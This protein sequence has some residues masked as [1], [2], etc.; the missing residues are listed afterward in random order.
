MCTILKLKYCSRTY[1]TTFIQKNFLQGAPTPPH[2]RHVHTFL[3]YKV[4]L[5]WGPHL[6]FQ[7]MSEI[8]NFFIASLRHYLWLSIYIECLREAIKK[9]LRNFR[10]CLKRGVLTPAKLIIKEKYG[11]LYTGVE[12]GGGRAPHLK[13]F[14]NK[15]CFVGP[16]TVFQFQ[17]GTHA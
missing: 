16:W 15:S 12:G 4:W 6:P 14:F 11:H 5:G 13:S 10:H 3:W 7:T 8:L 2:C 9:K 1:K 17:N